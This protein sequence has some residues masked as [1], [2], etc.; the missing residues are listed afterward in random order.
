MVAIFTGLGA[1]FE[2]GS[3]STLGAMGVLG[4]ASLGRGGEQVFLNVA[5][6]NLLI[7]KRDEFLVGSGP[8]ASVS[9]TYNSQG[10]FPDDNGDRWRQST[11]RRLFLHGT[12]NATGSRVHR[13]SAD[14]SEI[15]YNWN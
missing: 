5:S 12:A 13:I 15:V 8:D 10:S 9:R 14:G 4:E 7:S 2:R 6:G 3:G 1:G 11:D